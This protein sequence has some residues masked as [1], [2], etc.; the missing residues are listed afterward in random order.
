MISAISTNSSYNVF[1]FFPVTS[2]AFDRATDVGPLGAASSQPGQREPIKMAPQPVEQRMR[3]RPYF[4]FDDPNWM[5]YISDAPNAC[6]YTSPDGEDIIGVLSVVD[7][8]EPLVARTLSGQTAGGIQVSVSTILPPR[9]ENDPKGSATYYYEL[10]MVGPDGAEFKLDIRENVRVTQ[11]KDGHAVFYESTNITRVY[12]ADGT[13]TEVA[14]DSAGED[15]DSVYAL[16]AKNS[17]LSTGNGNNTILVCGSGAHVSAGNGNNTIFINSDGAQVSAGNG[18][19]A[20]I[21]SNLRDAVIDLGEGNNTVETQEIYNTKLTLGD[22]NN[23]ISVE[24]ITGDSRISAGNGNN[25]IKGYSLGMW[26]EHNTA[27]IALGNGNNR[28]ELYEARGGTISFG[29]GANVIELYRILDNANLLAGNGNN[30]VN[31]CEVGKRPSEY[32]PGSKARLI[33]GDGDNRVQ[34]ADTYFNSE[35][36]FGNGSNTASMGQIHD[37]SQ[38]A[39][40]DGNNTMAG[41]NLLHNSSLSF[42]KGDNYVFID[43][44]YGS[45]LLHLGA[46]TAFVRE[47]MHQSTVVNGSGSTYLGTG[48]TKIGHKKAEAMLQQRF[49]TADFPLSLPNKIE[50]VFQ[51]KY[52]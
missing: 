51:Q 23:N 29:D 47:Q 4:N 35:I 3:T 45:P 27:S 25:T 11:T 13:Y 31:I 18:N 33:F 50:Q 26:G 44:M 9:T 40:G 28:V 41:R 48:F 43:A 5:K 12:A 20:I 17:T 1:S 6:S 36:F 46:G 38:V 34:V 14:G 21:A 22:G 42:G 19:N 37:N 24:V 8:N 2:V 32:E 10:S 7:I 39:F 16:V 52:A 49:N 30:I 15:A